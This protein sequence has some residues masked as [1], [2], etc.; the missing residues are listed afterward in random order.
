MNNRTGRLIEQYRKE[1]GLTQSELAK[2][3]GVSNTAISK[4]EHGNNL[5]DITLLEPL[6][7][8][9]GI[10]KLSLFTSENE[11]KEKIKE[12]LK[13]IKKLNL[14]KNTIPTLIF[15]L[16]LLVTNYISYK[17]YT[18]K[19]DNIESK[20]PK[21]YKFFSDDEDIF[22][23]GYIIMDPNE[24]SIIFEH[25]NYQEKKLKYSDDKILSAELYMYINEELVLKNIVTELETKD[26]QKS[27]IVSILTKKVK[28]NFS[29]SQNI[30]SNA[31]IVLTFN[32]EDNS[33]L[34][35]IELKC[36]LKYK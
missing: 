8:I 16:L 18:H 31:R 5:P 23:S 10:D 7:E 17:V 36:T 3:L 12:K 4:W 27:E 25:F 2:L 19:L 21:L 22:V 14:I 11:S 15:L 33:L 24:K 35:Q 20:Q 26:K 13:N 29:I 30:A 1:K 9:L 32:S 6:S 28:Y 34:K